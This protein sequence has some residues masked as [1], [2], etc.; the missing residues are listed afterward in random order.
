MRLTLLTIFLLFSNISPIHAQF[1]TGS[2][3]EN[4]FLEG[5]FG[6]GTANLLTPNP[7]IAP[8]YQY[9]TNPP[10]NDGFY[11]ITN[12]TAIWS[13]LFSSWLIIG[14]N[15]NDPN[16]YMMVVNASFTPGLF[17]EETIEGL[18]ESTLYEFSADIINLI[19]TGVPDHI[20]PN[21]S[22]LLDGIEITNTGNIDQNE[23]WTSF[24][25]TFTTEPGQTSLTLSLRNNAPGGFGNDLAIDNISFRACGPEAFI[26][27]EETTDI[28][29][30][31]SP[32]I[33]DATII[34]SQFLNPAIQWQISLDEGMTW[35]NISG[36]TDINFEHTN[37]A[38]GMYFYRFLLAQNEDNLS[39]E[40]CRV[41]SNEKIINVIP[42][43]LLVID[44]I[45]EGNTYEVGNS[46]YNSTG[47]FIDSLLNYLGCDSVVTT[48]LTVL[49]NPNISAEFQIIK[50]ACLGDNTGSI[51][52]DTVLNGTPP[53]R[54]FFNEIDVAQATNF[55]DLEGNQSYQIRIED[56]FGCS[57]ETTLF[58]DPPQEISLNL[59]ENQVVELGEIVELNPSFNF[60]AITST[61]TTESPIDCAPIEICTD[62]DFLPINS[63]NV[64]L[65]L[66]NEFGCLV[67]DSIF[68][69]VINI[70]KVYFPNVFS[71]NNDGFNDF[72]TLFGDVPNIQSV[73]DFK[74]FDRW[75]GLIFET[76][77]ILPNATSQGWDGTR[78]G[79][80]MDTGV[81]VYSATVQFLDNEV[82]NFSG[83]VF[84]IR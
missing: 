34:G 55:F 45:C 13:G 14:D 64:T 3:G 1:C 74:I 12:N 18:C 22:F 26:L 38:S 46:I 5:D 29:E 56:Q 54:Y 17:Y 9:T 10:P 40:K 53:Y 41:I 76:E 8:G 4:I 82:F 78:N 24:G 23:T 60:S 52:I 27:P 58:I 42:K 51:S 30:D 63:Q 6:S 44:T 66:M 20:L 21:V 61:W 83:D 69:E 2:L 79:E 72:F 25:F 77:N 70:R 7:N 62:L 49:P 75:G 81:Y 59:G 71:P 11:T 43:E 31:S 35:Q 15:S 28:C 48:D 36:A 19:R 65:Q 50:P 32:L 39:A 68:I 37:V 67:S 16:G 80:L 47:I 73:V 57:F 84:L 33:L